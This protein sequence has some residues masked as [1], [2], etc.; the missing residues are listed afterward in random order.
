[1]NYSVAIDGPAGAGKSTMARRL[2][3][4]IS[5]VYV[6]TGAIYRAVAYDAIRKGVDT[7]NPEAVASI[8]QQLHLQL[9]WSAQGVQQVYL[10]DEPITDALRLP[11]VSAAASQVSAIAAVRDF[12][13]ETQRAVARENNVVMDGRDIG[14]VVLPHADV[15]IFLS[16]S[17]EVRAKRR[18][19]ELQAAG[20]TDSFEAV[21]QE[22]NERDERDRNR[23]IAPLR[24]ADDAILLDTSHLTLEQSIEALLKIVQEKLKR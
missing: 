1:M 7:K 22:M 17:A 4:A 9:H 2:A 13:L 20:R 24:P 21:L 8:L 19:L 18:W 10:A 12:L 3:Q 5:F 11:A 23:P 14:T 15:K 16:A 6:D